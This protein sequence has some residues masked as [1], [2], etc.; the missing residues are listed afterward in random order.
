MN[1]PAL[2]EVE[3]AVGVLYSPNSDP[4]LRRNADLFLTACIP[5]PW[6]WELGA[7]LL[8]TATAAASSA[9][10]TATA[11][12]SAATT[13]Y[14][15]FY[16]AHIICQKCANIEALDALHP[17]LR[18]QI[19]VILRSVLATSSV[20]PQV[21]RRVARGWAMLA[22]GDA[23]GYGLS[24]LLLGDGGFHPLPLSR[25]LNVLS[26]VA[27]ELGEEN[28]ERV[29]AD[30]DDV[31]TTWS[32]VMD[33]LSLFLNVSPPG[34]PL[35]RLPESELQSVELRHAVIHCAA[36]WSP[37]GTTIEYLRTTNLLPPL[38]S[39]VVQQST[40]DP[41]SSLLSSA[42][43]TTDMRGDVV[44]DAT[45]SLLL[46]CVGSLTAAF[47]GALASDTDQE[48]F[49]VSISRLVSEMLL[50][51]MDYVSHSDGRGMASSADLLSL[52]VRCTAC[53]RYP[54]VSVLQTEVWERL[55]ELE[56]RPLQLRTPLFTQLLRAVVH[57]TSYETSDDGTRVVAH[58]GRGGEEEEESLQLYRRRDAPTLLELCFRETRQEVETLLSGELS[59]CHAPHR[60]ESALFIVSCVGIVLRGMVSVGDAH[61]EATIR[62]YFGW[63]LHPGA[64]ACPRW[65]SSAMR[66]LSVFLPWIQMEEER[67]IV[68]TRYVVGI[69]R[70]GG[71]KGG[72]E[73]R[74]DGKGDGRE[75]G[76]GETSVEHALTGLCELCSRCASTLSKKES[77]AWLLESLNPRHV[78]LVLTRRERRSVTEALCGVLPR[79]TSY[80]I[81]MEFASAL[82]Q[83][84][85]ERLAHN[86][87]THFGGGGGGD[88]G[89][90]GTSPLAAPAPLTTTPS[91]TPSSSTQLS[92][93]LE[94]L[95]VSLLR[96]QYVRGLPPSPPAAAAAAPAAPAAAFAA[97]TFAAAAFA[98]PAH[99]A[100]P[101]AAATMQR[102][103]S[104][105]TDSMWPIIFR[106]GTCLCQSA[107]APSS[108]LLSISRIVE[109][110][111][112]LYATIVKTSELDDERIASILQVV[113][114]L[115]ACYQSSSSLQPLGSIVTVIGMKSKWMNPLHETLQSV[116]LFVG[117]Q[118][119]Q[120]VENHP[121]IWI[122][123]LKLLCQYVARCPSC[124]SSPA[125]IHAALD[126]G[127]RG[128]RSTH[129]EVLKASVRFFGT[130]SNAE[131]RLAC[132]GGGSGGSSGDGANGENVVL[133]SLVTTHGRP[134][135]HALLHGIG[136]RLPMDTI[137]RAIDPIAFWNHP[138]RQY[139]VDWTNHVISGN[140]FVQ[141]TKLTLRARNTFVL[142]LS[143]A[144]DVWHEG[145][146]DPRM[147]EEYRQ[148]VYEFAA[149][150]RGED[151]ETLE[152]A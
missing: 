7:H 30:P 8:A 81:A 140:E 65:C 47:V 55:A 77:L 44:D 20:D 105:A 125:L 39:H 1:Q 4:V 71:T 110:V 109:N 38:L 6:A 11:A 96:L 111:L 70:E 90:G 17:Q 73:G 92:D 148:L 62:S 69:V 29:R 152:D 121:D 102:L 22:V 135:L 126:C 61:A 36:A 66:A 117:S 144:Q 89:A 98:A 86:V 21:V 43:T 57:R 56:S 75:G 58:H 37:Y 74:G 119:E 46:R 40:F 68:A 116:L 146:P 78:I 85:L 15:S 114:R 35:M 122:E 24:T 50:A 93:D 10:A 84:T 48:K 27:A 32:H 2:S 83:P 100:P 53:R 67:V 19:I 108:S 28:C 54:A 127:V 130:L 99:V 41:A 18:S 79:C 97:A 45:S 118:Q 131:R 94:I 5:N 123:T 63:I 51:T 104:V 33:R 23:Q 87:A 49:C 59:S 91:S 106:L 103:S 133:Q 13:S 34:A 139:F 112:V 151:V 72:R 76:G 82:L 31:H 113:G 12:T 26:A 25:Q 134:F 150:C 136:H 124:L 64:A 16:G 95:T 128:L 129:A 101:A 60:M 147:M 88:G 145:R 143:R 149:A 9:A 80:G 115:F 141:S 142:G 137:R 52:A 42:L 14:A 120:E 3:A 132:G 107:P 138:M